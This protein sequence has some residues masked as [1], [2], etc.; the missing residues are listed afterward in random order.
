MAKGGSGLAAP[1][2]KA[3]RSPVNAGAPWPEPE[4]ARARV[5]GIQRK[6]H[7]WASDDQERRF[8]DLHNLVCD[9]ATLMVAWTRVRANRGSRSAGVDGQLAAY[10]EQV[11]GVERFLTELRQELRDGS[12]RPLPVKERMIPKRG[13][14]LRRL[15][16]ATVRDRVAQAALKLVLEPIF[17]VDFQPCSYG[18][19]PGRRAQDAI[20]EV[21]FLTTRS[22]EWIVEADVEACFDRLD[23]VAILDRVRR[24]IGDK[25]VLT[26]VKAFLK[27]GIIAEQGGLEQTV[28]GTPQGGIL[29]PLLA[30]IALS[31][32]DEYYARAWEAMGSATERAKRRRHGEANYRLVR[33]ADDWLICVAGGRSHAEALVAETEQV[34]AP[35]GLTLSKE[36]TRVTH[37]DEGVEFLGWRI[38]R[39]R[40][41]DGRPHVYTYP[42]KRSLQAVKAKVKEITRSDSN[43][44]LGQLLHRLN[45]VL[46]GWCAYFRPGVSSRTF[47]Y[48]RAYT[49]RRVVR[50]L[51]RKHRRANWRWLK[52]RYLPGWW[53]TDGATVLYNPGGVRTTRYR[54]RGKSIQT[55]WEAG[56]LA[57]SEPALPLERL[58]GL[59]AR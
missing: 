44:P 8:S 34:I 19:R 27:A 30:N 51:R 25:R 42:S 20:A 31:A 46:R 37:I 7:R 17:E 57:T 35:L 48:L 50:W 49:W 1:V 47:N 40:G 9:P 28:T 12:Y 24:R 18:F 11:L 3:G 2:W 16:I 45:P 29:S 54:Y 33:Y 52:R 53:P 36:K 21:H 15:G 58:E 41:R 5:L 26:L 43:Q 39:Q 56:V 55:P 13:G 38:K 32:L 59:I 14:K 4:A 22:Y 6:L 23:H 10:V